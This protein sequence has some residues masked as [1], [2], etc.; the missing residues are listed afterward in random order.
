M[1]D[2]QRQIYIGKQ[3]GK[4][5]SKEQIRALEQIGM[6]WTGK[7]ERVWQEQYAQARQYFET[8][9]SFARSGKLYSIQWEAADLWIRKQKK[10]TE[11]W[12]AVCGTGAES[13]TDWLLNMEGGVC[14]MNQ[15]LL[16]LGAGGDADR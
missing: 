16:I 9:G 3:H 11:R 6:C 2:Q 1:V 15:R 14:R 5:L 13:E 7:Q 8:Y 10:G 12:K 4:V